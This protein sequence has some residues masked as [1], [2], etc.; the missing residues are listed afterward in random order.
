MTRL[1][2]GVLISGNGSNLQAIIDHIELHRV[3]CDVQVVVSNVPSAYGL[4]R[5]RNAGIATKVLD[6][7]DF[8]TR[9]AYDRK[10]EETLSGHDVEALFLAGFMRILTDEF[11]QGYAGRML[12]IHPSLLPLLKGLNT[13]RRAIDEGHACHGATVHFVTPALDS[14]PV[15]V[16]GKL[17][18]GADDSPDT[19]QQRV[20]RLEHRI[21]PLAVEWLARRRLELRESTVFLDGQALPP[22][23]EEILESR[24]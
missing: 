5:A 12:N 21:Y 22:E 4:T 16:R 6:H 20:H 19:L 13:H 10:L 23:G 14:G 7:R 15:V 24:D 3:P 8:E 18:I 17:R 11:V 2:A 1:K 9:S